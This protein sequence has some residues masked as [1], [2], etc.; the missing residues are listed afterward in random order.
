MSAQDAQAIIWAR[1][2]G[3]GDT[4]F[5]SIP[6][7]G[8][9]RFAGSDVTLTKTSEGRYRGEGKGTFRTSTRTA[10]FRIP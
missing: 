10:V 3:Q 9:F 7:G 1:H 8:K 2:L 4:I 5:K 6:I